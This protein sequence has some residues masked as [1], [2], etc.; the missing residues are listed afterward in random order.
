MGVGLGGLLVAVENHQRSIGFFDHVAKHEPKAA[1][2]QGLTAATWVQDVRPV[3]ARS[4]L[5]ATSARV[6]LTTRIY[7]NMLAEPQDD[8]DTVAY[9]AADTLMGAYSGDFELGGV[10]ANVDLLGAHGEPL[11]ARAGY[12]NQSGS[13]YRVFD[14]LTPLI[15]NDVWAQAA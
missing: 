7:K 12:L 14:I 3:Q 6:E 1:P 9:T 13:L 8:I 10:V 4:G 5:A 2:Q 11:R 15:L